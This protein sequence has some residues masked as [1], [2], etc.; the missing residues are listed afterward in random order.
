LASAAAALL[1][2]LAVAAHAQAAPTAVERPSAKASDARRTPVPRVF[3][4]PDPKV[5]APEF[6]G[7]EDEGQHSPHIYFTMNRG[8]P[9]AR[10]RIILTRVPRWNQERDW[11]PGIHCGLSTIISNWARANSRGHA[12]WQLQPASFYTPSHGTE[13]CPGEYLGRLEQKY[14]GTRHVLT[15]RLEYPSLELFALRVRR[16]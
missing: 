3:A 13:L 9:R 11:K 8:I 14:R 16:S 2:A 1:A 7:Y 10:Y 5:P 12:A 4:E 15:L 6:P